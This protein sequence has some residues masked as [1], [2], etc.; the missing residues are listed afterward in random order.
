MTRARDL[1]AF[2]SNADGDIK[3]DTDTLFIDSYANSVGIGTTAPH[4]AGANF[5]I[6]TLNGA[7]GGGI[8]FSDDDVNQHMINT[9]DDNSLRFTRGSGLSD[10]TMRIDSNGNVGVLNTTPN[11]YT[12]GAKNL[13]VGATGAT[14]ITIASSN[15][16]NGSLFF[17]DGTT[18]NEGYRGYLQYNHTD[19]MF[20]IGAAATQKLRV[21]S[22]GLKFNSD[23]AAANA[24]DDY[25]EGTFTPSFTSGV[26]S[27][28]HN[29][30]FGFYT[31]VGRVVHFELDI[32]ASTTANGDIIKIDGLPFTSASTT[33]LYANAQINYQASFLSASDTGSV[34]LHISSGST[35]IAFYTSPGGTF[36]GT[37]ANNINARI[38]ISGR[39][40]A[41]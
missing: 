12:A 41:A 36:N 11:S 34:S 23:T 28:S 31:K 2:V 37:D 40:F 8:V 22:D 27:G 15:N 3:F 35:T 10:E 21:D 1:A 32:Q 9:T 4:D 29:H 6:L 18:G 7:K 33:R 17:A 38:I 5:S 13:V 26:A 30:Q 39:Y 16:T 14:G 25:E 24:L 19:D 20:S